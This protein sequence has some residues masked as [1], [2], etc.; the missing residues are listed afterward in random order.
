[1]SRRDRSD[2]APGRREALTVVLLLGWQAVASGLAR[3]NYERLPRLHSQ[4]A[5]SAPRQ[6][7]LFAPPVSSLPISAIVPARNEAA[8]LPNLLNSL[9]MQEARPAQ[10]IVMDDGS[11]DGTFRIAAEAGASAIFIQGPPD[12]WTGKNYACHLGAA[13]AREPW[14]LFLD[15]DIT[16]GPGAVATALDYTRGSNLDGLSLF[17][18]QHCLTFWER[19]LLPYAYA[20]YFAGARPGASLANGQ[21]ILMRADAY[22]RCGGHAAVRDSV[23]DDVALA[24][25]CRR[26]G[27]RLQ[28]ARGE[29]LASVRMYSGLG[30]IWRGFG[31]NAFRFVA[32]DPPGGALTVASSV[33]AT[34]IFRLSWRAW[35]RGGAARLLAVVAAYGI[36]VRGLRYWARL[37]GAGPLSAPLYPL[38]S[39]VFMAI[40]LNSMGRVLLRRGV[41]WKGRVIR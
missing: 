34:T 26:E 41:I 3:R 9:A 28:M 37:F 13:A 23:I 40:A 39:L 33:A 15:A 24:R 25:V 22:A 18:Q 27:V 6:A 29:E 31:K 11:E 35:R 14:L 36:G 17:L 38:S 30:A 5:I 20:H 32:A 8:A 16:L 1:L 2:L 10:V 7:S 19:L 21:F 4:G 12:G